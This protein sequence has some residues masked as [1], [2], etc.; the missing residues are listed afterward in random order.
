M[1]AEKTV[2]YPI[3]N[4]RGAKGDAMSARPA[5]IRE[6]VNAGIYHRAMLDAT[7]IDIADRQGWLGPEDSDERGWR[8]D[9]AMWL[10]IA[11]ERSGLRQ[12]ESGSYQTRSEGTP[13]MSDMEAWNTKVY[14][15]A[16]RAVGPEHWPQ[17]RQFVI[18]DCPPP[19]A[20]RAALCLQLDRLACHRGLVPANHSDYQ[21]LA[22]SLR[23]RGE[24]A[25]R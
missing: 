11:Y 9:A 23:S 10:R 8:L 5:V 25:W 17:L 1:T 18:E 22:L 12:R 14:N 21:R 20:A 24:G 16:A 4:D 2:E 13:E 19:P 3:L 6:T 7:A 15:D